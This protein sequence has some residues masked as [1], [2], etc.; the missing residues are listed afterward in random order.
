MILS[1]KTE[2]RTIEI[3]M[4]QL[5]W[6]TSSN[7]S[8][9]NYLSELF[10]TY[11]DT[12]EQEYLEFILN[13]EAISSKYFELISINSLL[14][15]NHTMMN[16]KGMPLYDYSKKIMSQ[17]KI[18]DYLDQMEIIYEKII[19]E[20]NENHL[21]YDDINCIHNMLN[22]QF[23]LDKNLEIKINDNVNALTKID[24]LFQ[25]LNNQQ[26][27]NGK[28]YLIYLNNVD[29]FINLQDVKYFVNLL[30][31]IKNEN[32]N[33]IVS[34]TNSRYLCFDEPEN[35]NIINKQSTTQLPNIHILVDRVNN[36]SNDSFL[37]NEQQIIHALEYYLHHIYEDEQLP[38]FD[39]IS[40]IKSK[41]S[42]KTKKKLL[43]GESTIYI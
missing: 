38:C 43:N 16:K 20:I 10:K 14:D 27:H 29:S 11:F 7:V 42:K 34:T 18:Q 33:V 2:V 25:L 17:I 8:D 37:Y 9:I 15:L 1:I 6:I 28:K 5:T 39:I 12:S 19:D 40:A 35:I 13:G 23:L 22:Q 31:V 24:Y 41:P 3:E 36:Y 4:N 26:M 32:I 30:S 21:I